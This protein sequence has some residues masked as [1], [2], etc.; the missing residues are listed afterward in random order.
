MTFTI[1]YNAVV[2]TYPTDGSCKLNELKI[3]GIDSTYEAI[4]FHIHSSSEHTMNGEHFGA[5]L[6]IVHKEKDGDRLAVV[7]IFLD[8]GYSENNPE[9]A[10]A[11]NHWNETQNNVLEACSG[12]EKK[13]RQLRRVQEESFDQTDSYFDLYNL[14]RQLTSF[15]QYTGG[16]TTPPCSEV[17][18]WNVASM[19]RMIAVSQYTDLLDKLYNAISPD[20]CERFSILNKYGSSNRPTQ[21]INGREIRHICRVEDDA[22]D[23]ETTKEANMVE[24]E[25]KKK[26]KKKEEKSAQVEK[27]EEDTKKK[28][29][30]EKSG[31]DWV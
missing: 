1:G 7:G 23:E 21:P 15:Y 24:E 12:T 2:G 9:F 26:K 11:M 13:K 22:D 28:A 10:I 4:Q 19:H 29:N 31:D 17:V 8:P 5:E 30:Q 16:L 20:N 25:D 27:L 3:P 6:H 18:D 14:L